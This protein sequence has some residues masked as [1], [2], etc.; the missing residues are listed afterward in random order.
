MNQPVSTPDAPS[1]NQ[2]LAK[3]DDPIAS[4]CPFSGGARKPTA[5][6]APTNGNWWPNQLNVKI[7][8]Q[9]SAPSN[10]LGEAFNYAEAFNSLDLHA[11][12][13]DQ[14]GRAHV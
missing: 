6:G 13:K 11:V 5:A 8:H 12:V 14:I 10:P 3:L 1:M 4:A 9:Q 7:L 2:P